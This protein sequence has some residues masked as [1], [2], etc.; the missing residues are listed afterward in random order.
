MFK[1]YNMKRFLFLKLMLLCSLIA[2][3]QY[4]DP[5]IGGAS[6]AMDETIVNSNTTLTFNVVNS[7]STPIPAGSVEV[8]INSAFS[9]YSTD[10][11][12]AP[13]SLDGLDF[14]WTYLGKDSWRGINNAEIPAFQGG[15]MQLSFNAIQVSQ[16]YEVTSINVQPISN[17]NAF[18]NS[19]FNDNV[20]LGI[21]IDPLLGP[22]ALQAKVLLQ[23]SYPFGGSMMYDSLRS[24]GLISLTEPYTAA[25]NFAHV[26]EGGGETITSSVLQQTG[27]DAIV[28]WVFVELRSATDST[29]VVTTRSALVQRDG[30]VVDVDGTSILTFNVATPTDYYIA[31]RHRNHL[32][33]MTANSYALSTTPVIVDFT[34]LDDNGTWGNVCTERFK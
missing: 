16:F 21:R 24:Q 28:D 12:S 34:T 10:G 20:Q 19:P 1:K 26:G 15:R 31:I 4:A 11:T 27:I 8:T 13:T 33:A 2:S 32:G 9:Y 7:G 18:L 3:A 6:F 5:A 30:D 17:F 23:G 25:A 22:I 14:T 29:Q